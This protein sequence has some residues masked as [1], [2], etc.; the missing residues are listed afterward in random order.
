MPFH[1][2]LVKAIR[3]PNGPGWLAPRPWPWP[4]RPARRRRG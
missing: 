2:D 4:G 1:I 3:L